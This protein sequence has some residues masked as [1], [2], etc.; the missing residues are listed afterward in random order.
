MKV[1]DI[2]PLM[3]P[4]NRLPGVGPGRAE[5]LSVLLTRPSA[6]ETRVFDLLAHRPVTT[7]DRRHITTVAAAP[8]K[9]P[10]TLAVKV[11]RHEGKRSPRAP[12]VVTAADDT[13]EMTI[14]YFR[15][16]PQWIA[17]SYPIGAWVRV[18]GI[19]ERRGERVQ[20]PH[21]DVSAVIEDPTDA[22]DDPR[23]GLAP[24]YPLT[25][26]ITPGVLST[27]MTAALERVP[28]LDEWHDP[29]YAAR[30]AF[31]P[32]RDALT[33]LHVPQEPDD[34]APQA[35]HRRRLAADELLASQLALAIVRD[36][37]RT[38]RGIARR[39]DTADIDRLEASLPFALTPAQRMAI[40]E[41]SA[42][43]A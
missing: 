12:S 8:D 13:G 28:V 39:W 18:S 33:A 17:A 27:L 26:G 9:A 5:R 30:A 1:T 3:A 25:Q 21:P 14:L 7:I 11:I 6:A 10:A 41:I 16:S 23:F 22:P 31:P 32:F 20:M 42:D 24:V 34:L 2:G 4:V 37:E 15:G 35:I 40:S 29:A 43:L 38:G 36:R 19:T